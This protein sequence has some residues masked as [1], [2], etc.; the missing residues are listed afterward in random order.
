MPLLGHYSTR[1]QQTLL[2]ARS[3][4]S[5][6]MSSRTPS[7]N[8][9]S[10]PMPQTP[11]PC[12]HHLP[13]AV[14]QQQQ[15]QLLLVLMLPPVHSSS[16]LL[17]IKPDVCRARPALVRSSQHSSSACATGCFVVAC[18]GLSWCLAAA[19]LSACRCSSCR[20]GSCRTTLCLLSSW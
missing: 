6:K 13:V 18:R 15:Q 5:S 2:S 3:L 8:S 19:S 14:L 12:Q 10:R 20:H 1:P 11:C 16:T 7:R 9:S 17:R 4:N